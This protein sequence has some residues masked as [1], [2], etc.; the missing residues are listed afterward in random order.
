MDVGSTK[1]ILLNCVGVSL[2]SCNHDVSLC[3]SP[4]GGG[5]FY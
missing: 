5:G 4:L 3:A 2:L 1:C